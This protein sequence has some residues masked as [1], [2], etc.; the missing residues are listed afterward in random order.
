MEKRTVV[1]IILTYNENT[2]TVALTEQLLEDK[3]VSKIVLVDNSD[4]KAFLK[5]NFD[6][7]D[8]RSGV[9]YIQADENGGYAAGNNI[10]IKYALNNFEEDFFWIIN[11]D[12]IIQ[13]DSSQEMLKV[14][15]EK[16]N[17]II[18]G[19]I[20]Y[21]YNQN[22]KINDESIIQ[23]YGGGW[24][25]HGIGKSRLALKGENRI[26][27][28][29]I[30]TPKINFL[31]GA[32]MMVHRSI[33]K[34]VGLIPEEYFLYNE[35]LDWQTRAKSLGY[36]LV[37]A[38]KSEI[39]HLDSLSTQGK[40]QWYYY[41]LNRASIILTKKYY[42]YAIFTVLAYRLFEIIFRTPKLINKKFAFKGIKDG[43]FYK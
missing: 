32:S 28:K 29:G 10:G 24:Y 30:N 6:S 20:L 17:K 43:F 15:N 3:A 34:E 39:I 27:L 5:Q 42:W 40:K 11:N 12:I 31:I 37:I 33:F 35:E 19:S 22:D 1:A 25:Y 23:C 9:Y 8:K 4:D 7:F 36:D 13:E 14:F 38:K 18:C 2:Y 26:N 41:Y 16:G 21:Y